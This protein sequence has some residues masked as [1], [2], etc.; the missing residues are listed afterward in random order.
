MRNEISTELQG[1]R[2]AILLLVTAVAASACTA[3]KSPGAGANSG[4]PAKPATVLAPLTGLIFPAASPLVRRPALAVKI[5]NTPDA[6]PQS[7]L[8]KADIVYEEEVEGGI[9]RFIAI[10]QSRDAAVIGP[11]RSARP[12]DPDILRQ[13]GAILAF[14]GGAQYVIDHIRQT[15]NVVMLGP[16][17]AGSAFYRVRFR[18]APHNLYSSTA[19]LFR[20]ERNR[21]LKPPPP[22]FSFSNVVPTPM[23][24]PSPSASPSVTSSPSPIVKSGLSVSVAFS[25]AT[26]TANWRWVATLKSYLRFEGALPHRSA[27]G[28]QLRAQNVLLVFVKTHPSAHRDAAGNT[29]PI[30]QVV[31]SGAAIL[32]R[33]GVQIRGKWVRASLADP[34][35]FTTTIGSPLLFAPGVTWVELAPVGTRVRSS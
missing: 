25:T 27:S 13:Y 19:A 1:R 22:P 24:S 3:H 7:G 10:F 28:Q 30:A 5:E 21:D 20:I 14:S 17:Q 35:V 32:F 8:E 18:P 11:V 29:T 12:E 15:P 16:S 9:T 33:N 4:S 6:R 2:I 26:Y 23:P 31:G 34:M